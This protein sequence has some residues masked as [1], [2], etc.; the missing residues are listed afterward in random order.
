VPGWGI[1]SHC[2]P[3][4][5]AEPSLELYN[6]R[7][8]VRIEHCIIGSIQ[9]HEDEVKVDPI[10]ILI[11][12]SIVDATKPS[13][14]AIGAPGYAVAHVVLTILRT[15]VFGIVDVHAVQLAENCIF[16][17]CIN[18]ARRQLGCVRFSYVQP[19]CRTPRRYRCQPDLVSQAVVDEVNDVSKRP[20]LIA[21]DRLRVRPQFTSNRYGNPGYAQLAITC[22]RE[23]CQGADDESEM[24]AFHNLFKAQREANLRQRLEEFTP[25]GMDVG[26]LDP[27]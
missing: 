19:H 14:E 9:I 5:P 13:K 17:D 7:A 12:D 2:Q 10:P 26:I 24:G 27:T 15:T 18:V 16:T 6:L 23:V 11:S 4:R 21:S 8:H 3:N 25:A 20:G 1:D 22:A